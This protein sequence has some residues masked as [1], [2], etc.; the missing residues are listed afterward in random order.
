MTNLK[1]VLKEIEEAVVGSKR[2]LGEVSLVVASKYFSEE[3]IETLYSEGQ[4]DFGENKV[5]DALRKMGCLP[6][7]IRWHFIGHLQKNKVNKVTDKF[8]L[9]HSIDSYELAEKI[10][11]NSQK[12]QKVLLQVNTSLEESKSGFTKEELIEVLP[13]LESLENIE[14]R[15][16]MT[17]AP[18]TK[19]TQKI[20]ECFRILKEIKDTLCKKS[21]L[22][23]MGMSQDFTFAIEEGSNLVR[24]GSRLRLK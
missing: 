10:S 14:I 24:I 15:G 3:E 8:Y 19:E 21:W 1:Q 12:K 20:R 23:S 4:R 7:D 13:K 18:H 2:D 5:Q 6:K 11:S 22:L 16:L 9:I 17:M